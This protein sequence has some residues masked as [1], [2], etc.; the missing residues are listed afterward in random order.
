MLGFSLDELG[1]NFVDN[2]D[3][4]F[5]SYRERVLEHQ[6]VGEVLRDLWQRG[7]HQVEVLHAEVD[8]AGYDVVLEYQSVVRHVQLKATRAGGKR[9]SVGV[10]TKLTDKPSGCVIWVHFTPA[11][12]L[13]TPFYWLGHEAGS[14]LLL[15]D[16]GDRIG[17][18]TKG[19]SKGHKALRQGIR[20]VPKRRFALVEN[21]PELVSRLFKVKSPR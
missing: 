13:A 15:S 8:G 1:T 14:P 6:L 11:L 3:S 16:L 12:A 4:L 17:R 18:H 19:D 21:V 7:A 9:A 5:S 2:A 10:S 20:E